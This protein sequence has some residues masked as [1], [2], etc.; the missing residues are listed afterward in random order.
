MLHHDAKTPVSYGAK[1]LKWYTALSDS[2]ARNTIADVREKVE[3]LN[4]R[5]EN[6]E[7]LSFNCW[8]T[9]QNK[10]QL[11]ND[12]TGKTYGPVCVGASEF[13]KVLRGF[14]AGRRV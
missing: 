13:L 8:G 2:M 7:T 3:Y 4:N 1:R 11:T 10:Y 12:E 9:G 5:S 6:P 14:D